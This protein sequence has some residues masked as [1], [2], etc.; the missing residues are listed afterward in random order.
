MP[1]YL[2]WPD[3]S[4]MT[5]E[6]FGKVADIPAV[7]N[8]DWAYQEA[9]SKFIRE[10]ALRTYLPRNARMSVE[11]LTMASKQVFGDSICNFLEWCEFRNHDWRLLDYNTHI[12]QGYQKEMSAGSFS[13]SHRGLAPATVNLRVQEACNFLEWASIRKLRG[14][15]EVPTIL[16]T[17][18]RQN[19]MLSHGHKLQ[20]IA[21]RQGAA[22]PNPASL[23]M[24]SRLSVQRW[25]DC[26]RIEKGV[27]KHLMA[28]LVINTAVRREEA[29]Q[30]RT[31][32]LPEN[33]NDW[34]IKGGEVAVQVE[35][36][37]KG[38]KHY[39]KR[40]DLVGPQRTVFL[41]LELAEKIHTYRET[42]RL[43]YF[44]TYVKKGSTPEERNLRKKKI[45]KQLFLSDFTGEPVSSQTFYD[46]WTEATHIPYKGWSPHLGR[47]YW[48]CNELLKQLDKQLAIVKHI[49]KA[50]IPID[51]IRGNVQDSIF[52]RIRPQ[53]GHIDEKTTERYVS[54]VAQQYHSGNM[55]DGF[56]LAL[57][58]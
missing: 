52:L 36:G 19:P 2:V 46:A 56:E 53:L 12:L 9:P 31:H 55:S 17:K 20:E 54:W 8:T 29:V 38:P 40:G 49:D 7:F 25:L 45:F 48:A 15:F 37:A 39:N 14:G 1:F 32:T 47:H 4:R 6:G 16:I 27:T 34:M 13:A 30:W 26:V 11:V 42:K 43:K 10:R 57:E 28:E 18:H 3:A 5:A 24:P 51:W 44:A 50:Q 21:V 22:R 33:K 41:P 35:Y 58:E 23:H